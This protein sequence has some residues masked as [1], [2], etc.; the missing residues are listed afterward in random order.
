LSF[1]KLMVSC[2]AHSKHQFG[3]VCIIFIS[4]EEMK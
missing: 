2:S 3:A 4:M 1:V